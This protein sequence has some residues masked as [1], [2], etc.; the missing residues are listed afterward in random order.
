VM[1]Y[2][3]VL[4]MFLVGIIL[5][6]PS[7]SA[8]ASYVYDTCWDPPNFTV[9]QSHPYY[10]PMWLP[11]W[12]FEKG[13]YSDAT[14][15]LTYLEQYNLPINIYAADPA[16]DTSV[17]ANYNI[18]FGTVPAPATP[19]SGTAQFNLL[20]ALGSDDFNALFQGQSTLYLVAACH[21]EF[22]KACL[23]LEAVPVPP[24]LLLFASGLV[25]LIGLRRRLR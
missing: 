20:S 12:D 2:R 18:L 1:K 17:A 15:D 9:D 7:G 5:A 4:F 23:H 14:F 22:D 16:S 8:L 24:T 13:D 25:G 6:F 19:T 10:F 21:Y 11:S 3:K